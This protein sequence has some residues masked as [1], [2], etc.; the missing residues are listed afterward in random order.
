MPGP[1]EDF[2]KVM[3]H[4]R[5]AWR[6]ERIAWFVIALMLAAALLG[7]FG[8]GVLSEAQVGSRQTVMVEYDRLLR[9]SAPS[10]MRFRVHPSLR[11]D[12][13]VRLRI[14]R[15]I[16]SRMEIESIVPQPLSQA[17]GADYNEFV[18]AVAPGESPAT[19]DLRY[20]PSTFGRMRGEVS[21]AGEHALAIDQFV[22]P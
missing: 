9:S 2:A 10:L 13:A 5:K 22:Y 21:I 17:S 8:G 4:H 1:N 11:R 12:G 18:F 3:R 16:V 14:D 15:S 7:V 19:I 6:I 20:R